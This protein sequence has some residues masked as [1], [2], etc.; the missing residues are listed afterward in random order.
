MTAATRSYGG[1]TAEQRRDRRRAALL[2]AALDLYAEGGASAVT[3]RAVCGRARLNDRYFYEHFADRDA[4]LDAVAQDVT[5]RGLE[6]VVP[7]ALAPAPD[8]RGQI[9][10]AVDAAITFVTDDHRRG[11]LLLNSQAAEVVQR[12]RTTSTHTIAVVMAEMTRDLLGDKAPDQV[13]GDM[14]AYAAVSGVME[15]VAAW[16]RGEFDTTR[17]HLVDL[18]TA[19]LTAGMDLAPHLRTEID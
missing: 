6:V 5:A 2:D 17:E 8:V 14:A 7:A 18:V 11:Q 3:K 4:I 19:M 13:D 10:A 12:A 9:H 16:L 15:L 1:E